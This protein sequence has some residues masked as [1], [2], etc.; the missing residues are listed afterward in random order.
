MTV[1][2]RTEP[3]L[4]GPAQGL[5]GVLGAD[6]L[7]C[8]A[9]DPLPLMWH[10]AYLL[11]RPATA[12]LGMDGHPSSGIPAPPGEGMRRM[13]AGGEVRIQRP[14]YIGREATRR[15][16]IVDRRE[17]QGRSGP[18]TFVT[19]QHSIIQ[20][21]ETAVLDRQD[22]VYLPDRSRTDSSSTTSGASPNPAGRAGPDD[23]EEA[24]RA[25]D[26][27]QP[28]QPT[29]RTLFQFSALTYNAHR[30]H[31]DKDYARDVEGYPDLVV[32]GPLQALY[33]A[34]AMR[35]WCRSSGRPA[36][37]FC[38]YRL[39]APLFLGDPMRLVLAASGDTVR[40]EVRTAYRVTATA[41]FSGHLGGM[42]S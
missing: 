3:L 5:A 9:A 29:T 17:K 2:E 18:L 34:E 12:R 31:Y 1:L 23:P 35:R 16:E 11:E 6:D 21:G 32:H 8:A 30:I 4:P 10:W 28:E 20:D 15:S 36:P 37:V 40:T 14:L 22:I 13:F 24:G 25:H 41:S 7:R 38:R 39:L 27:H 42:R 33:L 19:V 26:V